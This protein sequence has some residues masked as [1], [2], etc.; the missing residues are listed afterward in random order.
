MNEG[1]DPPSIRITLLLLIFTKELFF[2]QTL[3][4]SDNA[5]VDFCIDFHE[6][7]VTTSPAFSEL[8]IVN[9]AIAPATLVTI[10]AV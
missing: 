6:I 1:G 10:S 8:T 4:L 7:K 9:S 2:Q 3:I 5:L